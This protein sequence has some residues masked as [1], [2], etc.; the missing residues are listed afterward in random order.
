MW[1][2]AESLMG[3][4]D[5]ERDT[6]GRFISGRSTLVTDKIRKMIQMDI[7][8]KILFATVL[9]IDGVLYFNIQP[10]VSL[11][12]L[13]GVLIALPLTI[14]QSR[15]LKQFN[16]IA[17]YGQSTK[18]KLARTLTFLRNRFFNTILSIS[19]TG[20]FLYISGLLMYFFL[21][22]GELR[23]LGNM[24][25]FVFSTF[26]V[27]GVGMNFTINYAQVRYHIKHIEACLSDLNDNILAVVTSNI[28]MQQKQDRSTKVLIYAVLILGFIVLIAVL[29]KLGF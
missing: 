16:E 20:I 3:S 1:N 4:S 11:G 2:K 21:T 27:I 13:A 25:V 24:D 18:E 28:E 22:Y 19:A 23:R 12:C 15:V 17:D 7:V 8:L 6:I 14:I 9:L 29:K 10:A 26:L 5:Y